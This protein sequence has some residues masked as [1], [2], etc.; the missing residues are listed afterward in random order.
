MNPFLPGKIAKENFCSRPILEQKIKENFKSHQNFY[1]IGERRIGKTSVALKVAEEICKEQKGLLILIDFRS[2]ETINDVVEKIVL[3]TKKAISEIVF[4][5]EVAKEFLSR[6][7]PKVSFGPEGVDIAPAYDFTERNPIESIE[8]AL[9]LIVKT[10][11]RKPVIVI[12]DEFQKILK[13]KEHKKI[14]ETLRGKIQTHSGISYMFSG[15]IRN[16]MEDIFTKPSYGFYKGAIRV[17]VEQIDK[18]DYV[19]YVMN[20]FHKGNRFIG[21]YDI[22]QVYEKL[23]GN[24]GDLQTFFHSLWEITSPAVEITSGFFDLAEK[25][26]LVRQFSSFETIYNNLTN[27]Q[28]KFLQSLISVG[29]FNLYSKKFIDSVG[30]KSKSN[31]STILNHFKEV[32]ILFELNKEIRY[33]DPYFRLWIEKEHI[34]TMR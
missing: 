16:K 30:V 31:I 34:R 8:E 17:P 21:K 2:V 9:D 33:Y 12:I 3:A 1:L 7:F 27:V 6:V 28:K 15:S 32:E 5:K 10:D 26:I 13:I 18:D 11:K 22:G 14:L 4:D 23:N 25:N 19:N 24:T 20:I 29:G